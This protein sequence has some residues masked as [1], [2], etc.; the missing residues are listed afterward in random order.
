M[1]AQLSRTSNE[2]QNK[3]ISQLF[4]NKKH[5][6]WVS[7][8]INE[9]TKYVEYSEVMSD[10]PNINMR[11]DWRRKWEEIRSLWF[12]MSQTDV[13]VIANNQTITENFGEQLIASDETYC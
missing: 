5:F 10:L 2:R 11:F 8:L 7:I 4:S 3:V 1:S 13:E 12:E 9:T 6:I